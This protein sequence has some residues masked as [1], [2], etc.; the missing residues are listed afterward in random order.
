MTPEPYYTDE[1]VTLYH[2]DCLDLLPQLALCEVDAIVT[3]PPY[4]ETTLEWDRWPDGWPA[5]V[6]AH[7]PPE[8]TLWSFGSLRMFLAV[9]D[10]FLLA[11]W[12]HAQEIIWEKQNGSGFHNDRFRRVHELAVQWY[13]GAWGDTYHDPPLEADWQKRTIRRK[14]TP[15]HMG[16]I[17]THVATDGGPRLTTSVLRVRNEHGRA[18]HP[19]QKP[20][21]IL[22]PLIRY[23]SPPGGLVLDPFAGAGSTL[24][25]AKANGRRAI[26]I[27]A[28]ERYVAAAAERCAQGVLALD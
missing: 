11:G 17:R 26:G 24:V 27:E 10:Q 20:V 28:D 12:A 8:A 19:T 25:A 9:R 5:V 23:S 21:G 4:G 13:R 7:T 14:T 15:P 3:D 22:S 18:V 6:G 1:A 16:E 2:G